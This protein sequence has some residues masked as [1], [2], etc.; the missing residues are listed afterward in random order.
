MTPPTD[1]NGNGVKPAVELKRIAA[2]GFLA[3][4]LLVLSV[5]LDGPV[6]MFAWLLMA[7]AFLCLLYIIIASRTLMIHFRSHEHS[8]ETHDHIPDQE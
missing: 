6:S 4:L 1:Q 3:L 2:M 7:V 5:F 8:T